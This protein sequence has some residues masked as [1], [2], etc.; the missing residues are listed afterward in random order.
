[1]R[2]ENWRLERSDRILSVWNVALFF[3]L[4]FIIEL[5]N[6]ILTELN[7]STK[8]ECS[9]YGKKVYEKKEE[10]ILAKALF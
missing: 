5:V 3:L 2:Q 6:H 8:V 1:M 9:C 10:N 7:T 4:Y